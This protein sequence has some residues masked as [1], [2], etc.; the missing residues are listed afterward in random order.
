MG[1]KI[2]D[3]IDRLSVLLKVITVLFNVPSKTVLGK[4]AEVAGKVQAVKDAVTTAPKG[5]PQG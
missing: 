3:T 4:A 2:G 5:T 1:L